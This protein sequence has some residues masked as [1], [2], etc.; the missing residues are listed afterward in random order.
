[1]VAGFFNRDWF[2]DEPNFA[3]SQ[4]KRGRFAVS[5]NCPF[6]R[7]FFTTQQNIIFS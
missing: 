2:F 4:N 1:M 3:A 5:L 7:T 6:P